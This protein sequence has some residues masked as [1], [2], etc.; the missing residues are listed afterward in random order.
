MKN[1]FRIFS[2]TRHFWKWYVFMGIAVVIS[3]VTS[4]LHPFI[5]KQIVDRIVAKTG[6]TGNDLQG[7]IVFLILFFLLDIFAT[8]FNSFSGWMGDNLAAKLQSYLTKKFYEHVLSLDVGYF[9]NRVVGNIV[10]KMYRGI[11]SISSFIQ[12]AVN[13]FLPFFL[14]ATIT[15]IILAFYS[16]VIAILLALL[17]PAYILISHQSTVRWGKIENEKNTI[18]DISQGRVFESLSGIR[19]VKSFLAQHSEL[20]SYTD[21]RI[22]VEKL[23][24]SQSKMWHGYDFLRR[25]ALN[26]IL[27]C[28]LSYIVYFTFQGKY[29]IGEMTL[30]IQL[31]NQ[32]RFP[33][34]AMSFILGQIQRADAGSKDFFD[35]LSTK[36]AIMDS[37]S[38]R[39]FIIPP[40]LDKNIP[41]VSFKNVSFSYEED[42]SVLHDISFFIE[43]GKTLALVGE[44]GQGKSTIVNLLLRF[45]DP[46]SGIITLA[47]K[48][49]IKITQESLRGAIAVVFQDSLLFSGTVRE[50]ISYGSLKVLDAD[51]I[52]VAK[53][54]NAY[55][56]ICEFPDGFDTVIGERGM[57]LSGGQKQ[58]IAIARAMLKD[59]PIIILDEATSS[60][61]S[62]AEILVQ[63]G[64]ER[65]MKNRTSII[66]AHRLSTIADAD[67][68]LVLANGTIAQY[69]KPSDLLKNKSGYYAQ[70]VNLQQKLLTATPEERMQALSK[71]DIIG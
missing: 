12:N 64:L 65:L 43:K 21:K 25:A 30:L 62:R 17:F 15:I 7:I 9:D 32:A 1:I 48:D 57:K 39:H 26:V 61:D 18:I 69:G 45:Y 53:A 52:R 58:R 2:F 37:T 19:V 40:L 59:A 71:F 34:F 31:V 14:S 67:T 5:L 22:K 56:F 51:I 11:E 38:A 47:G 63:Q 49:I 44:S 68:V 4:I 36:S 24:V 33:L 70:M 42:K 60:L 8:V 66:I 10:N 50:N 6:G 3:S 16:P 23:T 54:A 46:D 29:T 28:I 27:F 55:D 20:Q 35:I 41:M 13:N